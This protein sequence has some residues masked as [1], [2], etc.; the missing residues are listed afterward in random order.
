MYWGTGRRVPDVT[1]A[2]PESPRER[3][4]AAADDLFR[5]HGIR[6][7]GVEAIAAE[8]GTNK[9]TLYRHFASKDDLITEWM[10]G[11]L[12]QKEAAWDPIVAKH[13]DDPGAQLAQ[14]SRRNAKQLAQMEG[15]GS[16][17]QNA[18]AELTEPDHPARRIIDEHR[19]REHR[20]ITE[21]C[22]GAGFPEPELT[23]DEFYFLLE[24][25]K[26]CT[27][28]MGL[29]RI[30]EHLVRLVDSMVASVATRRTRA[31]AARR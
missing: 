29:R 11:I 23:A 8:A 17:I 16:T 25:A 9:M 30:G 6:G 19:R 1:R 14:W 31:P 4:L 2:R 18:L 27:Q 24:G 10:R 13:P 12:A 22:R 5:R 15:R 3:I 20:R 21:L 26:N 7:V 28:C